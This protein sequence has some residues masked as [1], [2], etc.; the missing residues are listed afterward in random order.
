MQAI[1]LFLGFGSELDLGFSFSSNASP[2]PAVFPPTGVVVPKSRSQ[3]MDRLVPFPFPIP[4]HTTRI[5]HAHHP[6]P[7]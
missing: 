2:N 6:S 3:W 5:H 7:V 4:C 1:L